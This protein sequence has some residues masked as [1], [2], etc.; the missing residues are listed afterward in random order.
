LLKQLLAS[1]LKPKLASKTLHQSMLKT[2]PRLLTHQQS[3]TPWPCSSEP[4]EAH[5]PV[6]AGRPCG[7]PS[8]SSTLTPRQQNS[9]DAAT[10]AACRRCAQRVFP[11]APTN[12]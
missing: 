2:Q 7:P 12:P 10:T 4:Q 9:D 5:G 8:A 6:R 3:N 1:I 11:A